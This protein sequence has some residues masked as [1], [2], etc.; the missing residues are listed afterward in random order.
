MSV[1]HSSVKR[2]IKSLVQPSARHGSNSRSDKEMWDS[3]WNHEPFLSDAGKFNLPAYIDNFRR[4]LADEES[5]RA[6]LL[7]QGYE[8][9]VV[10][11]VLNKE[12]E[13]KKQI[14][15]YNSTTGNSMSYSSLKRPVKS[16]SSNLKSLV[17]SAKEF[18]FKLFDTGAFQLDLSQ[19]NN[20]SPL[21]SSIKGSIDA[22]AV[23]SIASR[24]GYTFHD[25]SQGV[26]LSGSPILDEYKSLLTSTA[27]LTPVEYKPIKRQLE[28]WVLSGKELDKEL[29]SWGLNNPGQV[30]Q[31]MKVLG[32]DL[33]GKDTVPVRSSVQQ[34]QRLGFK[35]P[36]ASTGNGQLVKSSNDIYTRYLSLLNEGISDRHARN[37]LVEEFGQSA[38]GDSYASFIDEVEAQDGGQFLGSSAA[39]DSDV[40]IALQYVFDNDIP[41]D[42]ERVYE[43]LV[44]SGLW[45]GE[46]EDSVF[47][48]A[49][50]VCNELG[51]PLAS[52][53]K[54]S[55]K[56]SAGGFGTDDYYKL[57][58]VYM[59]NLLRQGYSEEDADRMADEYV[60]NFR[61]DLETEG[62]GAIQR[63]W[64]KSNPTSPMQFDVNS[65]NKRIPIQQDFKGML[66][67]IKNW[68]K[69]VHEGLMEQSVFYSNLM[70]LLRGNGYPGSKAN[71]IYEE[72]MAGKPV[73]AVMASLRRVG[74]SASVG[75][76][77][78]D[79][80]RHR[81]FS[82]VSRSKAVDKQPT[83][84]Q[85][86]TAR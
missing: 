29:A 12:V 24:D 68:L 78:G 3:Y 49:F 18:Q 82:S 72:L 67:M 53:V 59:H 38:E 62:E 8:E 36:V 63:N 17:K 42:F 15:E 37:Q 30:F 11:F 40:G 31:S 85:K 64:N 10:E 73:E 50:L 43:A 47:D 7:S 77:W 74:S 81:R 23:L 56:S 26:N 33:S 51:V 28:T 57:K 84:F 76:Y 54:R 13:R 58:T 46:D 70:R 27:S 39:P 48:L 83:G 6:F 45:E 25:L 19:D 35:K 79:E 44:M 41:H 75:D 2:P 4:G 21:C 1:V 20:G 65:S 34:G 80:E 71:T 60:V 14:D 52:S 55:I 86:P 66:E 22:G 32:I 5:L 9:S 16:S 61:G 69:R